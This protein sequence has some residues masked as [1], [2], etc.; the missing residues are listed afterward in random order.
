MTRIRASRS[1]RS[2]VAHGSAGASPTRSNNVPDG[3]LVG[4]LVM[5]AGK[6]GGVDWRRA[7]ISMQSRPKNATTLKP[8]PY[9][10][11]IDP[12]KDPKAAQ[13]WWDTWQLTEEGKK[14]IK[15]RRVY[16]AAVKGF[17]PVNYSVA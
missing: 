1:S 11:Y 4:T 17:K 8:I 13:D 16:F 7:M 9:P 3:E 2:K 12:Q 15:E 14:F 10:A 5:L 6:E